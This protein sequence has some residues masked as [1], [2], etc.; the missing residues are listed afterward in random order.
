M[1]LLGIIISLLGGGVLALIV[2]RQSASA[3][4]WLSFTSLVAA[5]VFYAR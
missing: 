5:S 2:G 1:Q 4:R 3:S